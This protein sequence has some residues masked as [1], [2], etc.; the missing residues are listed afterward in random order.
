VFEKCELPIKRLYRVILRYALASRIDTEY[1][2]RSGV[3][4]ASTPEDAVDEY[5]DKLRGTFS[6]G[7]RPILTDYE[8]KEL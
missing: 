1:E 2:C 3:I 6:F 8:V 7:L 4:V 5:G